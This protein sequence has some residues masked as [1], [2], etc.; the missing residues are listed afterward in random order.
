MASGRDQLEEPESAAGPEPTGGPAARP[1]SRVAWH[2]GVVLVFA[3]AGALFMTARDTAD[4]QGDI[5]P[6]RL[7]QLSDVIRT[8]N[9]HN[10]QLTDQV[11]AQRADLDALTRGQT[12]DAR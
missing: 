5:R 6:E 10:R 12:A 8:Q 3:L 2:T 4:G 11:S 1:R 7:S 9:T